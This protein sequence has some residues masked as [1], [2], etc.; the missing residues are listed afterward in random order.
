MSS[1]ATTDLE[2]AIKVLAPDGSDVYVLLALKGG[3]MACFELG[4][5]KTALAV[6]HR[7]VD[8]L[9]FVRSG[10]GEIWRKQDDVE[11]ITQLRP[12]VCASI[13]AG[14]HFQFRAA[15]HA[16]VLIVAVTM[17]PWPGEEEAVF[18]AGPWAATVKA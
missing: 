17:P 4:A 9:W 1:F 18:V 10:S 2:H 6:T 15:E 13:P 16:S 14:T 11:E 5:G 8:E 12:G 3:S 7:T